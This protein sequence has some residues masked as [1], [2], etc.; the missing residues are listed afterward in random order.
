MNVNPVLE[1]A[2]ESLGI[3]VE[4]GTYSGTAETYITYYILSDSGALYAD[5]EAQ[6]DIA[7]CTIDIYSKTNYKSLL[8]TV[9]SLLRLADFNV[10]QGPEQ[11]EDDTGFYHATIEAE[12][13]GNTD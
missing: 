4:F 13:V 9:K 3:P 10:S 12:I 5:D 8:R 6:Y 2:L 7:S 1:S 11:Y